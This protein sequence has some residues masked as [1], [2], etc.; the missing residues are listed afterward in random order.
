MKLTDDIKQK[1]QEEYNFWKN[2]LWA[3]KDKVVRA[4][5]GQFATPPELVFKMLEKFDSLEDKDILDPCLGAGNLLAGAV[6]AGADPKRCYG[7]ELDPD[8]REVCLKRLC[9]MGVPES[10]IKLGNALDDDAYEFKQDREVTHDQNAVEILEDDVKFT[11]NILKF[12]AKIVKTIKI[13]KTTQ[14][15]LADK[16][17][18]RLCSA[19]YWTIGMN[20]NEDFLKTSSK[21][22][23][24][25]A[26]K[27]KRLAA[28]QL[29]NS[30]DD[31][32]NAI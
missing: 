22:I 27:V 12:P 1:I 13:D 7:I 10:N 32:L 15:H 25:T 24:I 16:L 21:H 30:Y 18:K 14:K 2:D 8:I 26:A 31:I 23:G 5:F 28:K 6:I 29:L 19:G 4:K 11:F 17:V 20:V 3:G 9:P